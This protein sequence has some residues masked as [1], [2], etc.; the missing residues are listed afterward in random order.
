MTLALAEMYVQGVSTRKVAAITE[1]LCGTDISSSQVRRAAA[2]LDETLSARRKRPLGEILF[3]YLDAQYQRVRQDGRIRD[4]AILV[5]TG[6]NPDGK[7]TI[8]GVST[9]M[10]EQEAH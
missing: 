6:V 8:V 5:A 1:Q 10:G 9:A 4:A 3:L 2:L 7:R